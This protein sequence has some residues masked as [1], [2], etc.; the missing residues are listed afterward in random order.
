[1]NDAWL[2]GSA[3]VLVGLRMGC[4]WFVVYGFLIG[5]PIRHADGDVGAPGGSAPNFR[6]TIEVIG[7][8]LGLRRL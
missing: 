4:Q 1:M 2:P 3:N 8:K 6:W 5:F 7:L